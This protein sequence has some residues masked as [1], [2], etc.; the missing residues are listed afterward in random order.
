MNEFAKKLRSLRE[1]NGYT[2]T[3]LA[4]KVGVGQHMIS[5]YEHG[6]KTPST[7]TIVRIAAVLAVSIDELLG[8]KAS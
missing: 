6:V 3:E 5:C 7:K 4:E 8:G 2:Q 1:S